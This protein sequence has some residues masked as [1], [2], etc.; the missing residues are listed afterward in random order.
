MKDG[1]RGWISVKVL[2]EMLIEVPGDTMMTPIGDNKLV[3][4]D[5]K[6]NANRG[7]IDLITEKLKYV[8]T[9]A[10]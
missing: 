5:S 3:L 7:E 1:T 9:A 6:R 2:R 4:R 10:S 8:E